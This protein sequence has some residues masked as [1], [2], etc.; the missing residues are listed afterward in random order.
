[1][2]SIIESREKHNAFN[3]KLALEQSF[4]FYS[5]PDGSVPVHNRLRDGSVGQLT[6]TFDEDFGNPLVD[7]MVMFIRI[8][9]IVS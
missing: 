1:M 7:N 2:L 4:K 3:I 6:D 5:N 8:Q 9:R